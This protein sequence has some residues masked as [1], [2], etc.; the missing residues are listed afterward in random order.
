VIVKAFEDRTPQGV[1]FLALSLT[2]QGRFCVVFGA[3]TEAQAHLILARHAEIGLDLRGV[4]PAV[5]AAAVFKGG[6]GP[7]LV[8]LVTSDK[9]KLAEA[10]RLAE[11]W[12]REKLGS[13]A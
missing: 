12:V 8:E 5:A 3:G 11:N 9:D 2:R 13:G 6:G 7:S 4:V 1:R 10:L